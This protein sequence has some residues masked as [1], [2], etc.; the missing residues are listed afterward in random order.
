MKKLLTTTLSSSFV[1]ALL[2]SSGIS[3]AGTA[4]EITGVWKGTSNSA[5]YGY[6]M[7]HP[8]TEGKENAI[9][10][11]NV[12]YI[13]KIDRHEGRN[14]SG[15]VNDVQHTHSEVVLGAFAKDMK[16]GVMVNENGTFQFTF[17]S[18]TTLDVCY[19]QVVPHAVTTP[20]VASCFEL[21]KE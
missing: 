3:W 16:S 8:T 21:S 19:S 4:P 20:R 14:F 10:Y 2:L 9:R 17:S 18:P 6:G 11:R 5:V 7:F 12:E 1:S 13:I 15:M